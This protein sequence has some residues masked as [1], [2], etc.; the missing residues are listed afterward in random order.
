MT[1]GHSEANE[2]TSSHREL[3]LRRR[4]DFCVGEPPY[5]IDDNQLL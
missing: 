2:I 1:T 4:S 5:I 3:D